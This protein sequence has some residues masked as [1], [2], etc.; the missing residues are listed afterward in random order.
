MDKISIK[1]K[2]NFLKVEKQQ[3][4]KRLREISKMYNKQH[5]QYRQNHDE[6]VMLARRINNID[7]NSNQLKMKLWG[8]DCRKRKKDIINK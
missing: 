8:F 4:I 3:K 7:T 5:G 1:E 2:I 6:F